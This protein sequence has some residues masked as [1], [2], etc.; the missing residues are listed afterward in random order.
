MT[1]KQFYIYTLTLITLVFTIRFLTIYFH[2]AKKQEKSEFKKGVLFIALFAFSFFLVGLY[3][4]TDQT[5]FSLKFL[6]NDRL[7]SSLSNIFLLSSIIYFPIIPNGIERIYKKSEN[8]V[9]S[10]FLFF[11]IIISLFTIFD[12]LTISAGKE[13]QI[14][15]IIIDSLISTS[16]LI[17]FGYVIVLNTNHENFAGNRFFLI[18]TISSLLITQIALP[19]TKIFHENLLITYPYFLIIF[20]ASL[21]FILQ[22][23][24]HL[25]E[26]HFFYYGISNPYT[27]GENLFHSN[28]NA[29]INNE[30]QSLQLN[31]LTIRY[32]NSTKKY[33]LKLTLVSEDKRQIEI[34]IENLKILQPLSYWIL[35]AI[36]KKVNIKIYNSDLAV[37]RFRMIEYIHKNYP[38]LKLTPE[39]IFENDKGFYELLAASSNII[40]DDLDFFLDK[41]QIKDIFLK[42]LDNY[43]PLLKT[44]ITGLE[45]GN[46]AQLNKLEMTLTALKD[47]ISTH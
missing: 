36:S 9:I 25:F 41:I 1:Y 8:W 30:S 6:F 24:L 4:I 16:I 40:I 13:F 44:S 26:N 31:A 12:K 18:F 11:G 37:A 21:F 29:N 2:L 5:V 28:T 34:E 15:L 46:K 32:D 3:K 27:L 10:V 20:L 22:S 17:I 43:T 23:L 19:L 45:K 42:H 38:N 47:K 39:S 7:L 35:F 33:L 14:A